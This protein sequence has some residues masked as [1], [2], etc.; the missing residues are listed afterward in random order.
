MVIIKSKKQKLSSYIIFAILILLVVSA[1]F[2]IALVIVNSFKTHVAIVANPLSWPKTL[3]P[4]NYIKAW[5]YAKFGIGFKNSTLLAFCTILIVLFTSTLGGYVL[6]T[7]KGRIVNLA[8]V[9]FVIVMTIPIQLFLFPLY[10]VMSY[11]HLV[12]TVVPIS[13]I[14]AARNIPLALFLMRTFFLNVPKELEEAARIDG[15]DTRQVLWYVMAPVVSP[16]LLTVS[17][18]VGLN[19]WNEFLITSTFLQGEKNFTATLMLRSMSSQFGS[20]IGIMMAGAMI[21]I[22]PVLIFFMLTQR[23]FIDG[24]VSGSVKG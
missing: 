2:P 21:L 1:L 5:E 12:G 19:A 4:D 7:R 24:L 17:V 6:A 22:V 11:L 8:M 13:F 15:A 9:Y 3:R 14:L 23:Y 20:D 10:Y 18:I 16:G